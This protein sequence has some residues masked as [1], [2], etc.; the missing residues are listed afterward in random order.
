[1]NTE[2][3]KETR[4]H[5]YRRSSSWG[6]EAYRRSKKQKDELTWSSGKRVDCVGKREKESVPILNETSKSYP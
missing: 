5:T 6:I 4:A 1:M 2:T 3:T